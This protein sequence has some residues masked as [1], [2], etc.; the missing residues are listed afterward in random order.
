MDRNYFRKWTLTRKF[1]VSIL[2]ALL[3]VFAAMGTIISIHEKNVLVSDLRD[4]G[5]N[6]ARFLAAISAE[7][8]LSYNLSFLENHVRY[9]SEGDDD[10]IYAVIM[11]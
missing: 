5:E 6:V 11:D 9:V 1:L 8:I 10:I 4:K 2:L 3:L 7:P